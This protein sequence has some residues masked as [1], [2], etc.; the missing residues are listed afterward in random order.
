MAPEKIDVLVLTPMPLEL[1]ALR[2]E[3]GTPTAEAADN[4]FS[5]VRWE[6]VKLEKGRGHL[7]AV[8]PIEKDQLP[9]SDATHIAL[10]RWWPRCFVLMGIA[11]QL[12][13]KVRLGDVLVCRHIFQWD[14]KR[15]DETT[16]D[17]KS[18]IS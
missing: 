10:R 18:Q 1:D 7:V 11:G 12:R 16:T 15:K 6:R 2:R 8:L 9:A 14:A 5:F 13:D 17:G 4:N 3:L